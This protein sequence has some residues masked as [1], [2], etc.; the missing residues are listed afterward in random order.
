MSDDSIG[1]VSTR[2][3]AGSASSTKRRQDLADTSYKS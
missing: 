2:L 3:F 1:S